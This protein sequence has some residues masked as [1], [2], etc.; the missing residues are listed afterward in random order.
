MVIGVT[1][2]SFVTG[3][4]SSI[5]ANYDH[6]QA[7][8]QEKLLHLNK[9]K[10]INGISDDL[11]EEIRSAVHFDSKRSTLDHD[12]FLQSLPLNLRM[13]LTMKIHRKIFH[14]FTLFT[15]IGNKYFITW[16]STHLSP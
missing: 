10:Q 6:N 15:K 8:L 1:S 4:L 7:T 16:I 9:L 2:F 11:Y 14:K 5:M 3:S 12:N 13:E